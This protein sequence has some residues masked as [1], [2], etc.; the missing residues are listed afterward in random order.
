MFRQKTYA[1]D[2]IKS[3]FCLVVVGSR[4]GVVGG[5]NQ[6]QIPR[7]FKFSTLPYFCFTRLP[8]CLMAAA[9]HIVWFCSSRLLV[10]G[11]RLAISLRA[12][13]NKNGI[14]ESVSSTMMN[15]NPSDMELSLKGPCFRFCKNASSNVVC[16]PSGQWIK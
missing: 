11:G 5:I 14:S 1:A 6:R 13:P 2:R 15:R 12:S 10:T 7:A 16:L 9:I 4:F 8:P 3:S